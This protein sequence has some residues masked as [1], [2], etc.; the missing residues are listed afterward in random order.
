M[1]LCT[2]NWKSTAEPHQSPSPLRGGVR[3][4]GIMVL[5]VLLFSQLLGGNAFASPGSGCMT[6]KQFF[7]SLESTKQVLS[8]NEKHPG[9]RNQPSYRLSDILQLVQTKSWKSDIAG[10][11]RMQLKAT[12]IA[13]PFDIEFSLVTWSPYDALH[14]FDNR[15]CYWAHWSF[16]NNERAITFQFLRDTNGKP[17]VSNISSDSSVICDAGLPI[18]TQT[19][20]HVGIKKP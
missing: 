10:S 17:Y 7:K 12:G 20:T 19:N 13:V 9:H 18:N 2:K 11:Q 15:T 14:C 5:N 1:T 4:G 6:S 3:G 16:G 8:A